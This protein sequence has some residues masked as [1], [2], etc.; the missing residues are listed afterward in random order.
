ME[1]ENKNISNSQDVEMKEEK[2]KKLFIVLIILLFFGATCYYYAGVNKNSEKVASVPATAENKAEKQAV[3]K[4]SEKIVKEEKK[5]EEKQETSKKEIVEQKPEIKTTKTKPTDKT[6]FL[7]LKS[8]YSGKNDPFSYSESNTVPPG[9]KS[10]ASVASSAG[11]LPPVPNSSRGIGSL[12]GIPQGLQGIAPPGLAAPPAPKPEDLVIV[13]GFIGNK[14]I[15]EIGGVVEALST[16]EK[17]GNVK[18]LSVNPSALTAEFQI[19]GKK[20]TKIIKSLTED[21]TGELQLVKKYY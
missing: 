3:S 17:V 14:V 1:Q 13:K 11:N 2:T 19:N 5:S 15:V 4:N 18:V 8:Q 21:Y 20:Y 7:S 12:P 10:D 6:A 9:S 16:Y